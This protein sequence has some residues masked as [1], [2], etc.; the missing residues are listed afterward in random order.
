MATLDQVRNYSSGLTGLGLQLLFTT[1][2]SGACVAGFVYFRHRPNYRHMYRGRSQ[3]TLPAARCCHP[4]NPSSDATT[5]EPDPWLF[6]PH[7]FVDL[8]KQVYAAPE[9][10]IVHH[11]G[12]DAAMFLRFNRMCI[13][14]CAILACTVAIVLLPVHVS[15]TG[16][17][18][19]NSTSSAS[20]FPNATPNP[21]AGN[22]T[23]APFPSPPLNPPNNNNN[24]NATDT[25]GKIPLSMIG[26]IETYSILN[27]PPANNVW[28]MHVI[29][30]FL[31]TAVVLLLIYHNYTFYVDAL[32]EALLRQA[33]NDEIHLRTV[34]VKGIPPQLRS[35]ER[36]HA[37]FSSLHLGTV[38]SVVMSR[39]FGKLEERID[40]CAGYLR[41][42]EIAHL[43]LAKV[44]YK[45]RIETHALPCKDAWAWIS[46]HLLLLTSA[47][48]TKLPFTTAAPA[49]ADRP[50]TVASRHRHRRRHGRP[51]PHR[52]AGTTTTVTPTGSTDALNASSTDPNSQPPPR[53]R[54]SG[55]RTSPNRRTRTFMLADRYALNAGAGLFSTSND[56]DDGNGDGSADRASLSSEDS[57]QDPIVPPEC[58]SHPTSAA[59]SVYEGIHHGD[60]GQ[61]DS[62]LTIS[63]TSGGAV[64]LAANLRRYALAPPTAGQRISYLTPESA[65]ASGGAGVGNGGSGLFGSGITASPTHSPRGSIDGSTIHP[66]PI[67]HPEPLSAIHV[68]SESNYPSLPHHRTSLTWSR[69]LHPANRPLIDSLQPTHVTPTGKQVRTIDYAYRKLLFHQFRLGYAR[70]MARVRDRYKSN[71]MAFVTFR[72]PVSAA[73]CAQTLVTLSP[74]TRVVMAPEPRDVI[75]SSAFAW[76]DSGK[77]NMAKLVT[78]GAVAFL[79]FM[80]IVPISL[81]VALANLEQIV[82]VIPFLKPVL[83]QNELIQQFLTSVLPSMVATLFN[84]LFPYVLMA[85]VSLQGLYTRS[86]FDEALTTKYYSFLFIN[87]LVFFVIGQTVITTTL[88][89]FFFIPIE[90]PGFLRG[91]QSDPSLSNVVLLV[92]RSI[93]KGARFFLGYTLYQAVLH[94]CE[95]LQINWRLP[96]T[97]YQS[98]R[99]LSPTP[100]DL[101]RARQPWNFYFFYYWP[102]NILILNIAIIYSLIHPLILPIALLY[103]AF[104]FLVFKHQLLYCYVPAYETHGRLFHRAVEWTLFGLV[105][106]QVTMIGLLAINTIYWGAGALVPAVAATVA[107]RWHVRH[108]IVPRCKHVPVEALV[109]QHEERRRRRRTRQSEGHDA[110]GPANDHAH[111]SSSAAGVTEGAAPSR[112]SMTHGSHLL[113]L[114]TPQPSVGDLRSEYMAGMA[115][116]LVD[117]RASTEP[118]ATVGA[119]VW[120]SPAE[121]DSST[122]DALAKLQGGA[123]HNEKHMSGSGEMIPMVDI[124]KAQQEHRKSGTPASASTSSSSSP[125]AI[126]DL[127]TSPNQHLARLSQ[128]APGAMAMYSLPTIREPSSGSAHAPIPLGDPATSVA[129]S[130]HST[131]AC[132]DRTHCH[133]DNEQVD[134][135]PQTYYPP[136]LWAS[137]PSA[138]WLPVDPIKKSAFDLDTCVHVADV[139]LSSAVVV[140]TDQIVEGSMGR[141]LAGP[142]DVAVA[143]P[144]DVVVA[145]E[146]DDDAGTDRGGVARKQRRE[147]R[148]GSASL[149]LTL[150]QGDFGGSLERV[151]SAESSASDASLVPHE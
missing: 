56:E 69:L 80:W 125:G 115:H 13:H 34:L 138:M 63:S 59:N 70:D 107:F 110:D 19:P 149:P 25:N 46:R 146:H 122:Q 104:G 3:S 131:V 24:N 139:C 143:R 96:I 98:L 21:T 150:H 117:K 55:R 9:D 134:P 151:G 35:E 41:Q 5:K 2:M 54:R 12:L 76:S 44:Y 71:P 77:R 144:A 7:R 145:M 17:G 22:R 73:I 72:S 6:P 48:W 14:A 119:G 28:Y 102:G 16:S 29:F 10:Y 53:R 100:R 126:G 112:A 62:N 15:F 65:A 147:S 27:L 108:A 105:L 83:D 82:A 18:P 58:L 31:I 75:W 137:L 97:F 43:D 36:L 81:V 128:S 66:T 140:E 38:E 74:T 64:G 94:A 39:R 84:V 103:F 88:N 113:G 135:A 142:V 101:H 79:I 61:V 121:S 127:P 8:V 123:K 136:C 33:A 1:L 90:I 40:K 67:P 20:P 11:L 47:M 49:T 114:F 23:T 57:D 120:P 89:L 148:R 132:M 78:N 99:L 130:I 109:R 45:D 42:L 87:Q 118:G 93:P 111:P 141:P 91:D 124:A 85:L 4:S 133:D 37:Y 116:T 106:F 50:E 95:L 68:E 32:H 51:S 129:P 52:H 86:R 30:A 60:L 92:A 26:A